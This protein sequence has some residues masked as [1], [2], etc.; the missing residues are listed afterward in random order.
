MD[1]S[2]KAESVF[3]EQISRSEEKEHNYLHRSQDHLEIRLIFVYRTLKTPGRISFFQ[4][5]ERYRSHRPPELARS[6]EKIKR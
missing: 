4:V 3:H 5:Q 2:N 1:S 6:S